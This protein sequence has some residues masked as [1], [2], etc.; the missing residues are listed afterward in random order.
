M[1]SV[2]VD[3]STAHLY[4]YEFFCVNN[5]NEMALLNCDP[6]SRASVPDCTTCESIRYSCVTAPYY[7]H[8][9]SVV[10]S[11]EPESPLQWQWQYPDFGDWS[12]S[13]TS[14]CGS[15]CMLGGY[16]NFAGS[17]SGTN[18]SAVTIV[19]LP[20]GE[21]EA[22]FTFYFIDS[23]ENEFAFL[24]FNGQEVWS[25]NHL[26]YYYDNN[27]CGDNYFPDWAVEVAQPV[28]HSGGS[29]ELMFCSNLNEVSTN[30]AWGVNNIGLYSTMVRPQA[31][32]GTF[33]YRKPEIATNTL[34]N[35]D[36]S[37]P[38]LDPRGYAHVGVDPGAYTSTWIEFSGDFGP[39][40][41]NVSYSNGVDEYLCE[42]S[43]EYG[44]I[45]TG[46][47]GVDTIMCRTTDISI[48]P[49]FYYLSVVAGGSERTNF[50]ND[51][52][53]FATV[54]TISAI[55]GCDDNGNATFNCTTGGGEQLHIFGESFF[56]SVE[57]VFDGLTCGSLVVLGQPY[58]STELSC[59]LPPGTGL[60]VSVVASLRVSGVIPFS[61]QSYDLLG[62]AG[63]RILQLSHAGCN[64]DVGTDPFSLSDCPRNGGGTLSIVGTNLGAHNALVLVGAQI[65]F[66][67]QHT[68]PDTE[69]TCTLPSGSSLSV[70]L[71]FIQF[72]GAMSLHDALIS[73]TPCPPG[74]YQRGTEVSCLPC[75]IGTSSNSP[76]LLFCSACPAGTFQTAGFDDCER[77]FA[78]QY[79][80]GET[81]V[82]SSCQPGRYSGDRAALC[83]DC[84][85]GTFQN[86]AAQSLCLSCAAGKHQNQI[87]SSVCLNCVSGTFSSAS[88][89]AN[90]AMCDLGEMQPDP[91]ATACVSCD[92]GKFKATVS[93]AECMDCAS[94]SYTS[95][96]TTLFTCTW[97]PLGKYQAAPGQTLCYDCEPGTYQSRAAAATCSQC[98]SGRASAI[99]GL[100]SCADCE[101]GKQQPLTGSSLC[102]NCDYGRYKAGSGVELCVACSAGS[103]TSRDTPLFTCAVCGRGEFQALPEATSCE[104][105]AAGSYQG[106]TGSTGCVGCEVGRYSG[107]PRLSSCVDCEAGKQQPLTGSSECDNCEIGKFKAVPGDE[108]CTLCEPGTYTND[109]TTLFACAICSYGQYQPLSGST[110]CH[111]CERGT[112]QS[113]Q[114][115]SGCFDCFAGTYSQ[116]TGSSSCN[117]CLS[118]SIQPSPAQYE[119]ILCPAGRFM[120]EQGS[121]STNC[122]AC[123]PGTTVVG[124]GNFACDVCRTQQ[125]QPEPG[126]DACEVC[127]TNSIH[128]ESHA[129]CECNV[130]F[131][132][133]PTSDEEMFAQ[134]DPD[135]YSNYISLQASSQVV[136]PSELLGFWCVPCP[137]GADCRARG[138]TLENVQPL[139]GY[140]L[141]TLCVLWLS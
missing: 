3:N 35:A 97:C 25:M 45:R 61:S 110:A 41:V 47:F 24:Y 124:R 68:V 15:T 65:C 132:A 16:G 19:D 139:E 140:F 87:G 8:S 95:S 128:L 21:Y 9:L 80:L 118:G 63:P 119:C 109:G 141:G 59:V 60:V 43:P 5:A 82:C 130:G 56:P 94:G 116:F 74:T 103:Y 81:S 44:R 127:P 79:S 131:Y 121:N 92:Y 125:F 91:G 31:F 66:N 114:S 32:N 134:L 37:E 77:C 85:P 102:D 122:T 36:L 107:I 73:F 38:I 58:N 105:C 120:A 49:G 106:S 42:I 99:A 111:D 72:K 104:H 50:S 14:C 33:S 88:G 76:G 64:V 67:V 62:Y 30:E 84:P 89:Q 11:W 70:P 138:T 12:D 10:L 90:C 113:E 40:I 133:I 78:G 6:E 53:V 52:L 27:F 26:Y 54:P 51:V 17:N 108:N 22:R 55:S 71:I 7:G 100:S 75:P 1:L 129:S 18:C 20:A 96:G 112:Y 28:T 46:Y 136:N 123:H 126:R 117:L 39:D 34:R 115:S 135:Q 101:A 4:S 48:S 69:I 86:L 98:E 23:W 13:R 93:T 29:A 57:V 137:E 2:A 83:L